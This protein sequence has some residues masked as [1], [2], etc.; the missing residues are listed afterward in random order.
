MPSSAALM[1]GCLDEAFAHMA[2]DSL[3]EDLALT[4]AATSI[5]KGIED[6]SMT[7]YTQLQAMPP[8]EMQPIIRGLLQAAGWLWYHTG[9][10]SGLSHSAVD[11]AALCW[12]RCMR[13]VSDLLLLQSTSGR[14]WDTPAFQHLLTPRSRPQIPGELKAS[15]VTA[16]YSSRCNKATAQR[17]IRLTAPA[18]AAVFVVSFC[19]CSGGYQLLTPVTAHA[20][21]CQL[22]AMHI[23]D[24]WWL[25][26]ADCP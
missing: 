17:H 8:A 2:S 11:S 1:A 5:M 21:L 7:Q 19:S 15:L 20:H 25:Q 3:S 23:C 14:A 4:S 10:S 12:Y 18:P 16:A 26:H 6:F 9:P 24:T 22:L 13:V